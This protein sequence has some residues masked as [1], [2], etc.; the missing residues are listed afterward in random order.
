MRRIEFNE[1]MITLAAKKAEQLGTIKNSITKGAGNVAGYLAEIA[2]SEHL[3][4]SNISCDPGEYKYDFDL[5]KNGKKIEVK[6]KRRTV[7][8]QLHY[9]VSIAEASKHQQTDFYAFTS[10]TFA[11]KTGLGLNSKYYSPESLWLCG[12]MSSKEY[13][14]RARFLKKGDIDESNGFTVK[15][16]MFNLPIRNLLTE[17]PE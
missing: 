11:Q 5:L 1:Q 15:A 12:F 9:E 2:L 4:C 14:K 8:P 3:G 16:N 13:F 7:D 17:L 6:T 10:I